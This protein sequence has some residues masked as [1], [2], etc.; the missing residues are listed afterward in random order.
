MLE[1][2]NLMSVE[3]VCCIS[4][5]RGNVLMLNGIMN[6]VIKINDCKEF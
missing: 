5:L 6:N 4:R 2:K 1:M 3:H